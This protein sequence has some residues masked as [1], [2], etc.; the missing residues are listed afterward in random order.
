MFINSHIRRIISSALIATLLLASA[1]IATGD[2]AADIPVVAPTADCMKTIDTATMQKSD[3]NANT[4]D[5]ADSEIDSR[6]PIAHIAEI[7][8]SDIDAV[9]EFLKGNDLNE[10]K[11]VNDIGQNTKNNLVLST[12][13]LLKNAKLVKDVKLILEPYN[14]D[15]TIKELCLYYKELFDSEEIKFN[16][17]L[18]FNYN[19]EIVSTV[20]NT[21]LMG[22]GFDYSFDL[23]DFYSSSDPWQRDYGFCELYDKLAF[24]IGDFY[25]TARIKFSYDDRDWMIQM[26]KGIYSFNKLGAEIGV[27]AK[28]QNRE[29]EF[30]D[31]VCD[32]DRLDMSFTLYYGDEEIISC[33]TEP[34]WWQTA[35]SVHSLVKPEKLTLECSIEFPNK[36]MRNAFVDSLEES[37]GDVMNATV[38]GLRVD[39]V[40]LATK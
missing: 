33:D 18:L 6:K 20:D 10:G 12:L 23:K 40:W 5:S 34:S 11:D 24:L 15:E 38:N 16:T 28:P 14:G 9:I 4:S 37:Y 19:T 27:Y 35:F 17:G 2:R 13:Y 7:T 8:L 30:Y 25:D 22:I 36:T 1:T 21:G 29:A 3:A 26:W 39:I 32:K 31:C